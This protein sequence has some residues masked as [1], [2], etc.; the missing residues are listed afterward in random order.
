MN[1]PALTRG[2]EM[3]TIPCG[4][5]PPLATAYL[6]HLGSK[7]GICIEVCLTAYTAYAQ[8]VEKLECTEVEY[9]IDNDAIAWFQNKREQ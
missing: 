2:L 7:I 6:K 5:L 3:L 4:N 9:Q 8:Y 1:S